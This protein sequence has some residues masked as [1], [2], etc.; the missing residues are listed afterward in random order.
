MHKHASGLA[1]QE[2]VLEGVRLQKDFVSSTMG[3]NGQVVII[4]EGQYNRPIPSKD[5]VTVSKHIK[6]KDPEVKLGSDIIFEA[7]NNTNNVAG[8][9]TT[10]ATLLAAEIV[11]RGFKF[12]TGGWNVNHI[13]NGIKMAAERV[14]KELKKMS[15]GIEKKEEIQDV[16]TIS[17]QNPQIGEL[18]ANVLIEIGPD[19]TITVDV[20]QGEPGMSFDVVKGM[21]VGNGF[22][23]DLFITETVIKQ[24]KKDEIA[25]IVTTDPIMRKEQ[26]VPM[27]DFAARGGM[28]NILIV[29][30]HIE[31]NGMGS[32]LHFLLENKIKGNIV[33]L[34]VRV[35]NHG[36]KQI[37]LLKDI[38]AYTG[39]RL[40]STELGGGLTEGI[41]S[42]VKSPDGQEMMHPDLNVNDFGTAERVISNADNTTIVGGGAN[43]EKLAEHVEVVRN[44][45]ANANK[46]YDEEFHRHRVGSFT[47]GVGV[48][49]VGSATEFESEE[50]RLRVDDALA[51]VR[52]AIQG[53]VLPGGGVALLRCVG[54]LDD[55]DFSNDGEEQGIKIVQEAIQTP[56]WKIAS[57]AGE[58]GDAIVQKILDS[59]DQNYGYDSA[60]KRWG[61][62]VKF[63]IID[64]TLAITS[65]LSQ[66]ASVS[67]PFL[68]MYGTITP[69][70]SDS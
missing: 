57:N 56:A 68:K 50:L 21:Q 45:A 66:A 59:K 69:L 29:G 22:L 52:S 5:G 10:C 18:I 34:F 55:M 1:A 15:I 30:P 62:M 65:A 70:P 3:P 19:S 35:P 7:A 42:M 13:S 20:S 43:K 37:D 41:S 46:G 6:P 38:A 58:K 24:Y 67:A 31:S 12:R 23:T 2:K 39:A 51:S 11:E 44:D 14:D 47:N 4:A 27:I 28:K 36:T 16:A 17:S 49:K 33:P 32:P 63:G 25:V 8:D 9:A 53:G 60:K 64:P 61:D 40:F 54:L 26:L 48:I